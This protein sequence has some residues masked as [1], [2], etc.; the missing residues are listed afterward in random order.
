[1]A[2]I[3]FVSPAYYSLLGTSLT[4]KLQWR[5]E[6]GCP[7]FWPWP[8]G[9]IHRLSKGQLNFPFLGNLKWRHREPHLGIAGVGLMTAPKK[10]ENGESEV[11]ERSRCPS[12]LRVRWSYRLWRPLRIPNFRVSVPLR[13]IWGS[14]NFRLIILQNSTF[15]RQSFW[16]GLHWGIASWVLSG[17]ASCS[18]PRGVLHSHV[19]A[20]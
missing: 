1:M 14:K 17:A 11:G 2:A 4:S 7:S 5:S 16:V 12:V 10:W 20:A 6:L 9:S 3:F 15:L 8:I 18:S 19:T 13:P